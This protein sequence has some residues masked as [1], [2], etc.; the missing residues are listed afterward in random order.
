MISYAIYTV[1][2]LTSLL[3]T[4]RADNRM[5]DRGFFFFLTLNYLCSHGNTKGLLYTE[6][7]TA[8]IANSLSVHSGSLY[9]HNPYS[10]LLFIST[11]TTFCIKYKSGVHKQN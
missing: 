10:N 1:R 9:E 5:E 4:T 8:D 6:N 7:K 11:Y 3:F 2:H